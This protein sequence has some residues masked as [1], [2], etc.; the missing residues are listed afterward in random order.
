MIRLAILT[1]AAIL[2]APSYAKTKYEPLETREPI[3]L[4][5]KGGARTEKHG[6]DYW[7]IGSPPMRHQVLGIIR[8]N[9]KNN[10]ISGNAVGSKAV[11]K[12]VKKAGGDGVVILSRNSQ[13]TGT[14]S[15][16]Q[17]NSYGSAS[18]SC[19]GYYCSGNSSGH[20]YGSGWSSAVVET[21][22]MMA[23]V[24]YLPD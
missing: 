2:A 23:V 5:G 22:T 13:Q 21:Y 3:I 1:A 4:Q 10:L 17:S 12:I 7:T 8:D 14:V 18:G 6:I 11:A 16:G 24:R 20:A 9:R 15:G 19:F